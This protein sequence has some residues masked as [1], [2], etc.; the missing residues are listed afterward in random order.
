M[1]HVPVV[2]P[3]LSWGTGL[4]NCKP[5]Q[6]L[7]LKLFTSG[8]F[9]GTGKAT[10]RAHRVMSSIAQFSLVWIFWEMFKFGSLRAYLFCQNW[11]LK[12]AIYSF[13]Y[14]LHILLNAVKGFI[15]ISHFLWFPNFFSLSWVFS[16]RNLVFQSQSLSN[17]RPC[18]SPFPCSR[19]LCT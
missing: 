19:S 14:K 16:N 7:F 9:P 4:P 18:L 6:S 15:M 10:D 5:K 1:P 11:E 17:C 3:P 12:K 8:W 13:P 2:T